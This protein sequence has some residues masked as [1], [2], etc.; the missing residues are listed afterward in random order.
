MVKAA[1]IIHE[2]SFGVA[3]KAPEVNNHHQKWWL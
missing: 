1:V 3:D 2:S